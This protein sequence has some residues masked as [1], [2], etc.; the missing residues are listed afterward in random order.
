MLNLPSGVVYNEIHL[1]VCVSTFQAFLVY[2]I[3]FQEII[4][5]KT[6]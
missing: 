4:R 5:R 2:G 1:G 3:S 6:V